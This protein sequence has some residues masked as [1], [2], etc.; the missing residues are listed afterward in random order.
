MAVTNA[1]PRTRHSPDVGMAKRASQ[2]TKPVRIHLD[3]A[4]LAEKL[5]PIYGES[6]PDFVS[7]RLRPMLEALREEAAAKL[8]KEEKPVTHKKK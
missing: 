2:D 8:L 3:V 4:E 5:A 6:V 7:D 1:L